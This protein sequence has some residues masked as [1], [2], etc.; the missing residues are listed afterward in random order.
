MKLPLRDELPNE[1]IFNDF[2]RSDTEGYL[3]TNRSNKSLL[4]KKRINTALDLFKKHIPKPSSEIKLA[5][6]ACGTGNFGLNLLEEGY[7]VDFID[8]EEHFF[9][10]I[11]HKN[12]ARNQPNF[13]KCDISNFEPTTKY[14]GIFLGEAI[15]HMARPD[16]LLTNLR[17][18]LVAGGVLCLTTPNGDYQDCYEPSWTEVKENTE[19]NEK[20]A[21]TMGNHVCE[22]TKKELSEL[23]KMAGFGLHEHRLVNSSKLSRHSLLRRI[24]P[25]EMIFQLDNKWAVKRDSAGKDLGRIQIIVAQRFH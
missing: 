13:I 9:K 6:F 7:V 12:T 3:N 8:N 15:E 11:E 1:T 2:L 18:S 17:N 19:R 5:D 22:F 20:L 23:V 16:I 4:N 25:R 14:H 21:N 24:L 10:Y